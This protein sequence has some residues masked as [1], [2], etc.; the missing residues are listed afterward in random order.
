MAP[1]AGGRRASFDASAVAKDEA[2]TAA[3]SEKRKL[4]SDHFSA[5]AKLHEAKSSIPFRRKEMVSLGVI[6]SEH[7]EP[8]LDLLRSLRLAEASCIAPAS[9]MAVR[10]LISNLEKNAPRSLGRLP[11]STGTS[12]V[13][14]QPLLGRRFNSEE[15]LPGSS[16]LGAAFAAT[17]SSDGWSQ[18][19]S[20]SPTLPRSSSDRTGQPPVSIPPPATRAPPPAPPPRQLEA[21]AAPPAKGAPPAKEDVPAFSIFS[22]TPSSPSQPAVDPLEDADDFLAEESVAVLPGFGAV[23]SKTE[24]ANAAYNAAREHAWSAHRANEAKKTSDANGSGANG[25]TPVTTPDGSF[26]SHVGSYAADIAVL[27]AGP[28]GAPEHGEGEGRVRRSHRLSSFQ[29]LGDEVV[30]KEER[31]IHARTPTPPA[32]THCARLSVIACACA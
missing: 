5:A 8:L 32:R 27:E 10:A 22:F 14:D 17:N 26:N 24:L 2:K 1:A 9:R 30:H 18:L 28:A 25:S 23:G 3:A 19:R 16:M 13:R 4:T 15:A 6:D 29:E 11:S 31:G 12:P 7:V 20:T 21:K